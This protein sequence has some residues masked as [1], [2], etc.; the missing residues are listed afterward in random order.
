MHPLNKQLLSTSI[1]YVIKKAC[2]TGGRRSIEG[3]ASFL[4]L[5][6]PC[7]TLVSLLAEGYTFHFARTEYPWRKSS[8]VTLIVRRMHAGWLYVSA[9]QKCVPL[10]SA[11]TTLA[12]HCT[13]CFF[14]KNTGQCYSEKM[15]LWRKADIGEFSRYI[16]NLLLPLFW[17]AGIKMWTAALVVAFGDLFKPGHTGMFFC[18]TLIGREKYNTRKFAAL[19]D[20]YV[21]RLCA[22]KSEAHIV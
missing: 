4:S 13:L 22:V 18:V 3:C 7:K 16:H 9:T 11:I 19:W 12:G 10:K 6:G 20:H 5:I 8:C 1:V 21:K 2:F 15:S 17:N 14:P